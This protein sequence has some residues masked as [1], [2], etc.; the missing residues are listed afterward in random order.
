M[1]GLTP[2]ELDAAATLLVYAL[3]P[4]LLGLAA[5]CFAAGYAFRCLGELAS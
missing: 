4:P 2:F 1:S 3:T 5:V